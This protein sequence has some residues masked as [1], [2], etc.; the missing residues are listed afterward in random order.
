MASEKSTGGLKDIV[1]AI[2]ISTVVIPLYFYLPFFYSDTGP[3]A[4]RFYITAPGNVELRF[5][6]EYIDPPQMVDLDSNAPVDDRVVRILRDR[7]LALARTD[8]PKY[9]SLVQ[10]ADALRFTESWNDQKHGYYRAAVAGAAGRLYYYGTV[11]YGALRIA[12]YCLRKNGIEKPETVPFRESFDDITL[13]YLSPFDMSLR[14]VSGAF[15][16]HGI[17][18]EKAGKML[19]VPQCLSSERWPFSDDKP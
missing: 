1:I 11:R 5:D 15:A 8:L 2:G 9:I 12:L 6:G 7:T 3:K 19:K 17:T 13:A 18:V 14:A 4:D 10:Q 16:T